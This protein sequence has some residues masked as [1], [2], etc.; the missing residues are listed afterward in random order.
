MNTWI[1][2]Y[3]ALTELRTRA[4]EHE[5]CRLRAYATMVVAAPLPATQLSKPRDRR[6]HPPVDAQRSD[7]PATR[8]GP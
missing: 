3:D 7:G 5:R 8:R 1:S 4:Q 6:R 2:V